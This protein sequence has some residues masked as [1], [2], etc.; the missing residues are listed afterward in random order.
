MSEEVGD[1]AAEL[2][3][4]LVRIDS[5]NPALVPGAAGE[6]EIV[7][8]LATHL[9]AR[10]FDVEVVD[11]TGRPRRPSLLAVARGSG[12]GRSVVLNGHLDTVGVA[13]M[14]EPF[15]GRVEGDLGTGRLLGRGAC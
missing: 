6:A 7:G 3:V 2:A 5:V 11:A 15:A 12:G 14:P 9:A 13:G 4:E 8:V 1:I 10:G